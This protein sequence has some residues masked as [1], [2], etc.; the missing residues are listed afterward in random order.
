MTA[1][2]HYRRFMVATMLAVAA[3][4]G[5]GMVSAQVNC[6]VQK[7]PERVRCEQ[8]KRVEKECAGRTGEALA[9]CRNAV[10]EPA[11]ERRDCK[12]LPEGY[13]RYKCEDE[14][15]RAEVEA[16]CG[17]KSGDA[18]RRCYADVMAKALAR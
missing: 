16:R 14:N 9:V 3:Q 8:E 7:E 1:R 2:R 4:A 13:G 15:L 18:Y 6:A 11:P 10:L 17:A 5:S 12:S